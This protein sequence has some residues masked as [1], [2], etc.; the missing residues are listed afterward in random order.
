MIKIIDFNKD[1]IIYKDV[2]TTYADLLKRV[3][4]FSKAL[5]LTKGEKAA[6]FMENRPE[7]IY[8]LFSI[9]E[10]DS[11]SILIDAMSTPEEVAYILKDSNP[12]HMFVSKDSKEVAAAAK[13]IAKSKVELI[14]VDTIDFSK[15]GAERIEAL[16]F[17]RKGKDDLAVIIYTSGTTGDPRGVMLSFGNLSSNL[18]GVVDLKILESKDTLISVLPFHHSYPLISSVLASTTIGMT[19]V[20][21]DKVGS[22]EIFS[23]LQ[24]Y[25]ITIVAGVPRLYSLMAKGILKKIKESKIT[26][27]LYSLMAKIKI[28]SL[29]KLVFKKVQEKFGGHVKCFVSGGAKLDPEVGRALE[30]FGF[31]VL[32]GYGLTETSPVVSWNTFKNNKI[33]SVGKPMKDV[34]VKVKDKEILVKGPTVMLGYYNREK[35]TKEAIKDNWFYTGDLGEIDSDGFIHIT[36]RKKEMIVL[37]NGKNINPSEVEDKMMACSQYSK[38]V[39][40]FQE[41]SGLSAIIFPD[42]EALSQAKVLN[43]DEMIKWEVVNAYNQKAADYKKILNYHIVNKELPKT[44]LNKL[45]RFKLPEL[46]GNKHFDDKDAP[47]TESYTMLKDYLHDISKKDV[48]AK[49]HIELD[50]GLDSIDKVDLQVF[51]ERSFGIEIDAESMVDYM[52][53]EQL[54]EY[55]EKHKTQMKKFDRSITE[56]VAM[57]DI[58]VENSGKL[59]GL[60]QML[61]KPSFKLFFKLKSSGMENIPKDGN[62]ILAPNHASFIDAQLINSVVPYEVAKNTFSLAFYE[63]F[64]SKVMKYIASNTNIITVDVDKN[65]KSVFG[66]L[67]TVLSK[68]KN[69]L[70]FPEGAITRDGE[71]LPFKNAFAIIA[72]KMNVPIIPVAIKGAREAFPWEATLPKPKPIEIAF[73]PS[74]KPEGKSVEQISHSVYEKIKKEVK[75][76]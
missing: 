63:Y 26:N 17:S 70:I 16:D 57:E 61:F 59:I 2:V 76:T 28:K 50:L 74:V 11:S 56:T 67:E 35:D 58:D 43:I 73:L 44:R 37:S 25:K 38:E 39:G 7:W 68:G 6:I 13:K 34:S 30:V 49:Q 72:K 40:V 66:Q 32:E 42:F 46:V 48:F 75:K 4:Y 14:D 47:K 33:G 24:K 21:V 45:R 55:V 15:F 51:L 10:L 18:E 54:A 52:V 27:F 23:A 69:L 31:T 8:S 71:L 1:A 19:N 60:G 36:G 3:K 65:L 64:Q 22:E 12:P 29:R 53:V 9:W 20:I 41:G 62:F 5:K